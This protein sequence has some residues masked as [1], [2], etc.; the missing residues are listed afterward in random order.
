MIRFSKID[1]KL[2]IYRENKVILFGAA[3]TGCGI[4]RT[5]ERVGIQIQYFCD[6]DPDKWNTQVKGVR[7]LS[8]AEL[9]QVCDNETIVQIASVAGVEIPKQLQAMGIT[10]YITYGEYAK[11][12]SLLGMYQTLNQQ[13]FDEEF[14]RS[15]QRKSQPG[16][17]Q[18][19]DNYLFFWYAFTVNQLN[20]DHYTIICM[21]PKTGDYTLQSMQTAQSFSAINCWH[22]MANVPEEFYRLVGPRKRKIITAVRDV[23]SQNLSIFFQESERYALFPE[24]WESGG[25]AQRI[26][27]KWLSYYEVGRLRNHDTLLTDRDMLLFSLRWRQKKPPR[28]VAFIIQNFF[29]SNFESY[30]HMDIFQYPFNKEKGYTIIDFPEQNTQLFIFQ[31]EK[32]NEITDELGRFVEVEDFHLINGNIGEEN[33]YADAYRQAKRELKF[34]R[35]YFDACFNNRIMTHFYSDADIEKFK[36][37]WLPHVEDW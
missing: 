8:P 21:P 35:A 20:L 5:L 36:Q 28:N 14:L 13:N 31:L 25:D 24:F 17:P 29:Q 34:P 15:V 23:I 12:I 16:I 19:V 33:W 11:R 32:L 1:D 37:R 27:Y 3:K 9:T 2:T 30:L 4:K 22:S 10:K 7:V 6:N 18:L 26:F